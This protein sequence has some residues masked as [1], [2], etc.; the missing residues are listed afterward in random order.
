[1]YVEILNKK[2]DII[3]STDVERRTTIH[4]YIFSETSN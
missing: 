3:L 4:Q 2:T 1:M